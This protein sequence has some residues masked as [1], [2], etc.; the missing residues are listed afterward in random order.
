MKPSLD[1][2]I[3]VKASCIKSSGLRAQGVKPKRFIK[4]L[5]KG[6]LSKYGYHLSDKSDIRQETLKQAV[7]EYGKGL[8]VKKL[9]ALRTLSKNVSPKNSKKYGKDIKFVQKLV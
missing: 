8:V 9:N 4:I 1:K 5:K 2:V 3:K 6:E 7:A